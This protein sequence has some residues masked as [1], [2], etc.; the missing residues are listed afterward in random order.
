MKIKIMR[1][2]FGGVHVYANSEEGKA[3]VEEYWWKAY[4]NALEIITNF[5]QDIDN[6]YET[7]HPS[8]ASSTR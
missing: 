6:Q 3:E 1:A 8:S 5:E 4:L 2:N 7:S